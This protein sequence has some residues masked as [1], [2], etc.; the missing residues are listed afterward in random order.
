M[1]LRGSG[2]THRVAVPPACISGGLLSAR[3]PGLNGRGKYFGEGVTKGPNCYKW[4]LCPH[5]W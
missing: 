1:G 5:P 4:A 3:G 2:G